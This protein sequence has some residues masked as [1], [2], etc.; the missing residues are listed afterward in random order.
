MTVHALLAVE[1]LL[2]ISGLQ[3]RHGW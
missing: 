2:W 1:A 3:V